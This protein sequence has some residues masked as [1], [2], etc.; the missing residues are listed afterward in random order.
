MGPEPSDER[1]NDAISRGR[2]AKDILSGVSQGADAFLAKDCF[3][4]TIPGGIAPD[5]LTRSLVFE[6][7][8]QS[9]KCAQL[10]DPTGKRLDRALFQRLQE[11]LEQSVRANGITLEWLGQVPA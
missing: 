2:R 4:L 6:L 10:L 5:G 7:L 3:T 9:P 1:R 8:L 11:S